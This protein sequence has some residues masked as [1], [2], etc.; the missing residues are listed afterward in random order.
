MPLPYAPM[1]SQ[2]T[3]NIS[4]TV[5]KSGTPAAQNGAQ[6]GRIPPTRLLTQH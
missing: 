4:H 2:H 6:N 3:R 1:K 5:M